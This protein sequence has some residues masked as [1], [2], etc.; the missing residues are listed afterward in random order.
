MQN[1]NNTRLGFSPCFVGD[2]V[3][4][5]ANTEWFDPESKSGSDH[6][7]G[8]LCPTRIYLKDH[9]EYFA[10]DGQGNLLINEKASPSKIHLCL[11]NNKV[12]Q[13]AKDRLLKWMGSA[14]ESKYFEIGEGD[15][16]NWCR[17]SECRKL[18][19]PGIKCFNVAYAGGK[20]PAHLADS[21]L[22]Y[23]N[24]LASVSLQ[25]Y[26]D[27]KL[28]VLAYQATAQIP[29]REKPADN[30]LMLL[31]AAPLAGNFCS[32]HAYCSQNT[33]YWKVY[34]GWK[35]TIGP[36]KLAI[37]E[38][39]INYK[40]IYAPFFCLYS[41]VTKIKRYHKDGIE[42]IGF[43]GHPYLFAELYFYIF[44]KLLWQ[45]ELDPLKLEREFMDA[46]Y[47]PASEHMSK[48]L[49]LLR[50]SLQ[51]QNKGPH[52]L[53]FPTASPLINAKYCNTAY[54]IFSEA[55]KAAVETPEILWRVRYAKLCA[56]LWG[57][58]DQMKNP[59]PI[60]KLR[61]LANICRDAPDPKMVYR[62]TSNM[63]ITFRMW[64][65]KHFGF[66]LDEKTW[67]DDSRFK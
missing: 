25:K 56:V 63:G 19:P 38:Y 29:L 51:N 4:L 21:M 50:E 54:T 35:N 22:N 40:N 17:C 16:Q 5:M 48:V 44:G 33:E 12:R 34:D 62:L 9:P 45:P 3:V 27:K 41:M 15:D 13:I 20:Y 52:Q 11:S 65:Q 7:Q 31:C 55:E 66:A 26:P 67:L 18:D 32:G 2:K 42:N 23:T 37:Y 57:D 64:S 43:N 6:T 53:I 58:L 30:M 24:D 28:L 10:R 60:P 59:E 14:L 8:A 46:F 61:E 1:V 49:A 47:G 36:K 39:I